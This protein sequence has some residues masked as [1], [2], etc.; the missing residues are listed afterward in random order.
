M[1]NH[2]SVSVHDAGISEAIGAIMLISVVVLGVAIVGVVLTSQPPPQKLPAVSAIIFSNG[3]V[4]HIYHDG[5]DTLKSSEISIL[6]NGNVVPFSKGGSPAPWTWSVG[7]TLINSTPITG[8]PQTV[9]IVYVPGSYTIA[10]ADFSTL[11]SG[12]APTTSGTVPPTTSPAPTVTSIT[13]SAGVPGSSVFITNLAGTNFQSGAVVRLTRA[14]YPDIPGTGVGFVSATQLT[15]TFNLAG[16]A[17]GKYTVVVTNPDLQSGNLLDGF[18]VSNAAPAVNGLTPDTGYSGLRTEIDNIAG[19]NFLSGA[20]VTLQQGAST[21]TATNVTVVSSSWISCTV[22][23]AGAATGQW[24]V[25]VTNPDLQSGT[26]TNLFTVQP[27]LPPT[28]NSIT[29]STGNRGWPVV[30]TSLAGTN[31]QSGASVQLQQGGSTITATDVTVVSPTNITCTF[32][33]AGANTGLWNVRVIN[34]DLQAGTGT[35]LFTIFSPPPTVGGITPNTGIR[36]WPVAITSLSGSAFQPGATVQLR[37]G[38]T[39]I[40]ATS[41]N[42]VSSGVITCTFD[43]SSVPSGTWNTQLWDV[44]VINTDTQ[45]ATGTGIF[46]VTNYVPTIDQIVP[47]TAQRTTTI[48]ATITGTGFQPGVSTVQL[49]GPATITATGITVVSPTQI[50]CTFAI[51]ISAPISSSYYVR[52]INPGPRT[53]NSANMFSVTAAPSPTITSIVPNQ[54]RHM[55]GGVPPTTVTITGTNIL[56]GARVYLYRGGTRI[57]T[58]PAGTVTPPNQIVTAFSVP[59]SVSPGLADVRVTNTDGQYF[60]LANGYTILT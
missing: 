18:T 44:R 46:T 6:V 3:S 4:V 8:T 35:G 27:A 11:G 15:C 24:N 21:I 45:F 40:T 56:A 47:N 12:P 53:G 7:D 59:T 52:V 20:T 10:S 54:G 16:A 26:G 58:A 22:D 36:G 42:V 30:I 1:Q 13:P 39:I 41:V 2:N 23:L 17:P 48:S 25:T 38:A 32:N 37:Q 9:R 28:V 49:R 14:G 51:P 55:H 33:L 19:T 60:T 29:P 50:T 43:L 34:P 5:G 57:Y 31:F